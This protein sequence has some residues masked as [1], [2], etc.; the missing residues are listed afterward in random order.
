M[1]LKL[2]LITLGVLT[3]ASLSGGCKPATEAPQ[4]TPQATVEERVDRAKVEVRDTA[5]GMKE[6]TF[7]QKDEFVGQMRTELADINR[8]LDQLS[9]RIG[10]AGEAAKAEAQPRVKSLREQAARLKAQLDAARDSTEST[11]GEVKTGFRN[12]YAELKVGFQQA[13]QWVSEKIAP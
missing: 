6:Y 9:E 12:G 10:K 8:E 3:I 5:Q 13:R 7:A 2:N 4:A 1:T 11:W